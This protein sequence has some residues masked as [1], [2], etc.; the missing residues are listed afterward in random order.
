MSKESGDALKMKQGTLME[1][2]HHLL[3]GIF[4]VEKRGGRVGGSR[5]EKKETFR[6]TDLR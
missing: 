1:H 4:R 3:S 2:L 6:E 5:W